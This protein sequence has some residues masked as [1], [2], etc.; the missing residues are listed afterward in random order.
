MVG[1][2]RIS[3]GTKVAAAS[4]MPGPKQSRS[5][6]SGQALPA[7]LWISRRTMT[8]D[9]PTL[10]PSALASSVTP[11]AHGR[12]TVGYR[13]TSRASR[14]GLSSMMDGVRHDLFQTPTSRTGS[15][16]S[17]PPQRVTTRGSRSVNQMQF[18]GRLQLNCSR[19][20]REPEPKRNEHHS[21]SRNELPCP[22]GKR[23]ADERACRTII[24]QLSSRNLH[25]FGPDP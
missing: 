16:R 3:S 24:A 21:P 1:S 10:A 15:H 5:A 17:R 8:S 12:S 18:A 13:P 14:A 11:S 20:S 2:A 6:P 25:R 22:P 23:P 9:A 4:T 7:S 19:A